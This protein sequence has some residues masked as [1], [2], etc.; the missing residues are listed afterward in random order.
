[1]FWNFESMKDRK[2]KRRGDSEGLVLK[3]I[4]LGFGL[5]VESINVGYIYL[6]L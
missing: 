1:M 6:M 2:S 5:M 3:I 4:W